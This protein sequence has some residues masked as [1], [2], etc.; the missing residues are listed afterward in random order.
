MTRHRKPVPKGIA[1]QRAI[2]RT[3]RQLA[4]RERQLAACVAALKTILKFESA[5]QSVFTTEVQ[6]LQRI[7]ADALGH[8]Y[9]IQSGKKIDKVSDTTLARA[10]DKLIARRALGVGR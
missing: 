7:A 4:I 5:W 1:E 6:H 2:T 9:E 3:R 8:A 10:L